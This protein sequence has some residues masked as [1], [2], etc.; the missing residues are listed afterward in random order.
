MAA[1]FARG[2]A[3]QG[4]VYTE[5]LVTAL[6]HVRNGVAPR[7]LWAALRSGFSAAGPGTRIGIV[8]D[9]IR[10]DGPAELESTFR[11]IDV[12][13]ADRIGHGVAAIDDPALLERLVRDRVPV[14][15]EN[16]DSITQRVRGTRG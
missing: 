9:A 14:G 15:V 11:L 8:V 4:I 3:A 7:D 12:L 1:A 5:V 6:T 2:Q 13:G 16:P 10:N